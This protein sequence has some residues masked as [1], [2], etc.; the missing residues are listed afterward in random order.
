M[1][2]DCGI[3]IRTSDIEADQK[4]PSHEVECVECGGGLHIRGPSVVSHN[5]PPCKLF[6]TSCSHKLFEMHASQL[7]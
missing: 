2:C 4:K 3:E 7:I 5:N 1:I 6:N